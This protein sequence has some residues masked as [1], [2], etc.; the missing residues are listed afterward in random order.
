VFLLGLSVRT[1][2]EAALITG[3]V[4]MKAKQNT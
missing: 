3:L 1:I 2:K 4:E